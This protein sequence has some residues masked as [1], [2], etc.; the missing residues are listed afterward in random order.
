MRYS[1]GFFD[2]GVC[3]FN[4]LGSNKVDQNGMGFSKLG[5]LFIL[6]FVSQIEILSWELF[7]ELRIGIGKKFHFFCERFKCSLEICSLLHKL[8]HI[9]KLI[10]KYYFVLR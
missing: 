7:K 9:H 10:A 8:L 4:I 2:F 6:L 5:Q 3:N 1:L